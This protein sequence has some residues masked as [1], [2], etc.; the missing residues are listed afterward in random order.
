MFNF[1]IEHYLAIFFSSNEMVKQIRGQVKL[2]LT[3]L[4]TVA[5]ATELLTQLL[6]TSLLIQDYLA[7]S[8]VCLFV[9]LFACPF[10]GHFQLPLSGSVPSR[11]MLSVANKTIF[12]PC[13]GA[14]TF[15]ARVCDETRNFQDRLNL[16]SGPRARERH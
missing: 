14:T 2:N 5:A 10:V 6:S 9:C 13:T 16:T 7:L 3:E 4:E 15:E 11:A 8:I 1:T 12:A